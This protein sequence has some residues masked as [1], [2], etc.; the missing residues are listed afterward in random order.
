M[1]LPTFRYHPDPL[2]T[3]SIEPSDVVCACCGRARGAIYVGPVYAVVDYDGKLCPWCIADGT[4]HDKL[5]VEFADPAGVGGYGA[6]ENVP[7]AVIDEVVQR[8]PCF[9][10][11]QQEQWFTHCGDAAAFVGRGGF[12]ELSDYGSEAI[13]GL[14]HASRIPDDDWPELL[15]AL[16]KDSSPTA[17]LFRC[18]HCGKFGGYTDSD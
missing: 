2:A 12:R 7:Q 8:T 9:I 15:E 4:A 10:G 3:G 11:W 17:Y 13:E 16:H 6:W 14:R 1:H 5:D 18:L